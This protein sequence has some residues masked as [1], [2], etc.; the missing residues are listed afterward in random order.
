MKFKM[1]EKYFKLK[2]HKLKE[3]NKSKLDLHFLVEL[4]K[5]MNHLKSI[6]KNQIL[7][8]KNIKKHVDMLN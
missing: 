8:I 4:I 3:L 2:K 1:L 5:E 7:K 6:F